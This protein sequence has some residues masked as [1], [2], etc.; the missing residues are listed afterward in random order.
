MRQK[1]LSL[2]AIMMTGNAVT[3]LIAPRT[4]L[5]VWSSPSA[6]RWYRRMMSYF[7]DHRALCRAL[8]GLELA[9]AAAVLHSASRSR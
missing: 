6:P 8:A 4:Q 9:G 2:L 5:R 1:A 3:F 7:G